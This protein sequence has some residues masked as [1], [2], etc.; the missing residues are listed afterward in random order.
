VLKFPI[1]FFFLATMATPTVEAASF[2]S[3][4]SM[5]AAQRDAALTDGAIAIELASWM[6][7]RF[8]LPDANLADFR[9]YDPES[10]AEAVRSLWDIGQKPI[11][12]TVDLLEANG[13]RVFSLAEGQREVDAFS[14]CMAPLHLCF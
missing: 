11:K 10:A 9:E 2:R 14:F 1:E 6:E 13:V 4:T 8:V 5:T 3:L 12:N 7:E